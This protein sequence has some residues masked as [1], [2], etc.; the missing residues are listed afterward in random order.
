MGADEGELDGAIAAP[1]AVEGC[2]LGGGVIS[3]AT[4]HIKSELILLPYS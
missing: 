2:V 3:L 4:F 1:F